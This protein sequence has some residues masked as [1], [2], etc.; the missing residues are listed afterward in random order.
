MK[1]LRHY[2]QNN[3]KRQVKTGSKS[4]KVSPF[5]RYFSEIRS[6]SWLLDNKIEKYYNTFVK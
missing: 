5:Q 1:R 3:A 6:F 4:K 2:I